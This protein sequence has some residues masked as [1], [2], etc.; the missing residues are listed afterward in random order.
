MAVAEAVRPDTAVAQA[1]R[2]DTAVAQA[3][4]PDTAVAQAFRPAPRRSAQV[5]I[6]DPTII[7]KG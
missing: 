5:F 6:E 2:P 1:F 7:Y 4:R 3:F